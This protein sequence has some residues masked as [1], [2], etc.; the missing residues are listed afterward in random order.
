MGAGWGLLPD[1]VDRLVRKREWNNAANL[2]AR[3]LGD[4]P[5]PIRIGLK[6]PSGR[7]AIS[8]L[9]HFQLFVE[10]WKA[11]SRQDWVEWD[12]RSYRALSQQR[13]PVAL[14]LQSVQDLID[15]LGD[16]ARQRSRI[17]AANMQPLTAVAGSGMYPV[18]VK[19]LGT[20]EEMS[21]DECVLLKTLVDQLHAGMGAEHY[22][23]SL[24]LTGVDTKFLENHQQ[25][26]ADVLDVVHEGAITASGGLLEWLEC[27]DSPKGW[28]WVRP[29][30]E[31]VKARLGGFPVMRLSTSDLRRHALDAGRVLVVENVQSG[32]GLPVLDDTVAVFGGGNNV[33]WLDAPWLKAKRV[34][35]WGDIDTWG[36]KILG[37][38][39]ARLPEVVP[40]MMDEATLERFRERAVTEP[41]SVESLPENLTSAESRLFEELKAGALRLEQ[42]RLPPDYIST[43]L[44]AWLSESI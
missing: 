35:Y 20:V 44:L 9:A 38:V 31:S 1:V 41:E 37:A 11:F 33:A 16:E 28:L 18:L 13:I 15:F 39:R 34:A 22:L 17:W 25:L 14:V 5:F 8:D 40:L 19:H 21:V 27:L 6:P 30:S 23:R 10:Q 42:E 7:S 32:Y 4:R 24:P 43:R 12:D 29:L 2:K 36:L 3:L 26:V